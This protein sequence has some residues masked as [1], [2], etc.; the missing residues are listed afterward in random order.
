[1]FFFPSIY[2]SVGAIPTRDDIKLKRRQ[3]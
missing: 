2:L 3:K 1:M